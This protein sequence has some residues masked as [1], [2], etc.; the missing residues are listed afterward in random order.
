MRE[1]PKGANRNH[2]EDKLN[3]SGFMCPLVI[4]RFAEYMHENRVQD[5][6]KIR[7]ADNWKKGI[8]LDSYMDSAWRHFHDI[9]MEHEGY[10]SREGLEKA[11]M[12]LLFNTMGYT[13]EIL[14]EKYEK[15]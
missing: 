6:G 8:P 9:W 4:E 1:F 15:R 14:K 13:H 12:G 7:E 2:N 5:D 10:K 3:F 11:L